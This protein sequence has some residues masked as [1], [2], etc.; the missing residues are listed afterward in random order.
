MPQINFSD[1]VTQL[2][3]GLTQLAKTNLSDYL[4]AAETDG[5][6][7]LASLN[8]DLQNWTS[9][10]ASGSITASDLEY[11]V[12]AKKDLIEMSALQQAG[13]A[14]IKLDA[15]KNSAIQLIITTITSIIKLC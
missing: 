12:N 2:E 10:L 7:M 4:A 3:S 8:A 6:Q 9:E 5:K 1:I 15:F 14:A 13:L 11:L